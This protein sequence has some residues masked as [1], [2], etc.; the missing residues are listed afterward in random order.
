MYNSEAEQGSMLLSILWCGT[1]YAR[2]NDI[3]KH[4]LDVV[5]SKSLVLTQSLDAHHVTETKEQP[6]GFDR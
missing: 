6:E 4:A 1:F 5:K 2:Y 3:A